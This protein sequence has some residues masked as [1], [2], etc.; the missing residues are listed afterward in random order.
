MIPTHL[1]KKIKKITELCGHGMNGPDSIRVMGGSFDAEHYSIWCCADCA[2]L[3]AKLVA[4]RFAD[5]S[6][7]PR[8]EL[9]P[10]VVS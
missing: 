8:A 3:V 5:V 7:H 9:K 2:H 1:S 4:V 6:L 10:K